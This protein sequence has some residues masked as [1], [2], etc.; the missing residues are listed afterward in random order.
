MGPDADELLWALVGNVVIG[1]GAGTATAAA[2]AP[3]LPVVPSHWATRVAVVSAGFAVFFAGYG[4]TQAGTY[5]NPDESLLASLTPRFPATGGTTSQDRRSLDVFLAVR[6]VFL[7]VGVVGLGA[8]M[9]LFALTIQ[10]WDGTLGVATGL[11]CIGG[12]ICGHIGMNGV[13]I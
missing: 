1:I 10:S 8:G 3:T 7:V 4:L 5:R 11:V 12:Y 6:G 13:V 2:F 9:R